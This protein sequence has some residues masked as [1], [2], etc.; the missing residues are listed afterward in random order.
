ML[1]PYLALPRAIHVLCVGTFINRAGTFL[2]PFLTLYL[3]S[4]LGLGSAFATQAMGVYGFGGLLAAL[5]GG[6][7]ADRIGRRT[8]MI[9][10]LAGAASILLFFGRLTSPGSIL[11]AVLAFSFLGE[12]YRPA[13][14]A[15]VADLSTPEQRPL[16]FSL[17]Y[18]TINLGMTV[19][20]IVG[21]LIAQRSFHWLFWGD[22]LTSAIYAAILFVAVRETLPAR[23]P[24]TAAASMGAV[25]A[26]SHPPIAAVARRILGHGTF[27][28]F[29]LATLLVNITYMQSHT[30]L[31]LYMKG[32]GMT[33]RTYGLVVSV[34]A[35]MVVCLQIPLTTV[36]G[37]LPRELMLVVSSLFMAAGFGLTGLANTAPLL[38]GTV[39][40]W[41]IGE[42]LQA[43]YLSTVVADLAPAD[44]R[45][46]YM[47]MLTLSFASAL[48]I[49]APLGGAVLERFGP[50]ALWMAVTGTAVAGAALYAAL[51]PVIRRAH[52]VHITPAAT[53]AA[54]AIE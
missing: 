34:N 25:S 17:M 44:L 14:S 20:P 24:G 40:V 43:P 10:S 29:C 9:V 39:V 49:G 16:A 27:L 53:P 48:M 23:R 36:T 33:P 30:T 4:S 3:T 1:K 28:L 31:P 35:F 50:G 2:I 26:P 18:L 19:S 22:A 51:A 52:A 54:T 5:T 15:M 42:L 45:G 41:T 8:V 47:G 13:A 37:R 21:G 12:M 46:T 6:H 38:A 7:L 32:L 11:A